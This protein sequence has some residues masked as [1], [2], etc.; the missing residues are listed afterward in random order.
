VAGTVELALQ[1][2]LRDLQIAKGQADVFVPISSFS[3]G[4]L[5]PRRSISEA[6]V[7]RKR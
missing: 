1:V 3:A 2:R 6:Q 7:W 4:R 5:I